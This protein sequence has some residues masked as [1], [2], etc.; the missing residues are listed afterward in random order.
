MTS[1]FKGF[2]NDGK[3]KIAEEISLPKFFSLGVRKIFVQLSHFY[4]LRY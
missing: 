4:V 3:G 2:G 1:R